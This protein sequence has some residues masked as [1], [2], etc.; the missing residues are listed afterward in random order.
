MMERLARAALVITL[1]MLCML[2]APTARAEQPVRLWHAYRGDTP[3]AELSTRFHNTVAAWTADVC[4][5]VRDRTG[6]D[7]VCLSGGCFQNA[8]LSTRTQVALEHA[9]FQ[10]YTHQRVPANDG[11]IS[12]G[13]AVV[14]YALTH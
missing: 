6:I 13:Q 7:A 9:G 3:I 10:V 11:G 1:S 5:R 4:R 14:A 8:L 12:L 2:L